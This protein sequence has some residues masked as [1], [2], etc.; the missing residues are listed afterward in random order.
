MGDISITHVDRLELAF[1]PRPWPFAVE[2]RD[3]IDAHFAEIKRRKPGVWNG[4]MLMLYDYTLSNRTLRGAYL[5]TDYASFLAW[6]HWGFPDRAM[7]NCFAMGAIQSADGAFVLGIMNDHTASAGSVYFPSGTPEPGD[8]AG[9]SVDLEAGLWRELMEETGLGKDD[10]A[11]ERGWDAVLAGRRIAL[12]KRVRS[13]QRAEELGAR[14]RGHLA[15]EQQPELK[16]V[17]F[18]HGPDDLHPEVLS[19]VS[20]YLRHIWSQSPE[21]SFG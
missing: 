4:R 21:K 3:E 5:E 9:M 6:R 19:F 13:P 17:H 12:M 10:L 14:I 16:D 2:R 15:R 20:A 1:A 18:V 7:R 11:A 8:V